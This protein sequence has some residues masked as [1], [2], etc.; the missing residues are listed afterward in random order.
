MRAQ[1]ALAEQEN[2]NPATDYRIDTVLVDPAYRK[3]GLATQLLE[4]INAS[5]DSDGK[6]VY[7]ASTPDGVPLYLQNGY[8]DVGGFATILPDRGDAEKVREYWIRYMVRYAKKV[9]EH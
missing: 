7:L 8:E 9:D 6:R 2:Y 5:A 1:L 4:W 3:Q